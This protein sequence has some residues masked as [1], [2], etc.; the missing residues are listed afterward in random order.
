MPDQKEFYRA[1]CIINM[2]TL[3]GSLISRCIFYDSLTLSLITTAIKSSRFR[4]KSKLNELCHCFHLCLNLSVAF[5]K[6][7]V[8]LS[9]PLWFRTH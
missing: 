2:G 9:V 6:T 8:K 1:I 4:F 5:L 7:E 3:V